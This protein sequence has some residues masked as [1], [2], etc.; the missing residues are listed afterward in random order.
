MLLKYIV[1]IEEK[2][3]KDHSNW[4][5][6]QHAFANIYETNKQINKIVMLL[7]H[8]VKIEE[9]LVKDYS[10]WLASQHAFANAY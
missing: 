5:A 2:L 1:K 4:L 10:N 9:K 6:S 3:V 8:I 7:K